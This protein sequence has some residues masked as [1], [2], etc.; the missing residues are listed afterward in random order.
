M[1][2]RRTMPIFL[3]L[4]ALGCGDGGRS[5][6]AP[7]PVRNFALDSDSLPPIVPG[8]IFAP[9]SLDLKGAL[10]ALEET[11]PKRFG[12][13]EDRQ[14]IGGKGRKSFAFEVRREPFGVQFSG[15][16]VMLS[17]IIHYRGRGWYDPPIGPD[18]NGEC[19]TSD[20]PPRAR[21]AIRVTPRLTRDWQLKVTARRVKVIPMSQTE[22]D[23]CEVTFL[24]INVTGRVLEA[25]EDALRSVLPALSRQL[26]RI[27]VRTPLEKIWVDL[28]QPIRIT[29]SL[30]LLLNPTEIH[31]G[32]V[33]RERQ[34]VGADVAVRAAPRILSGERPIVASIPLPRLDSITAGEGFSMLVE[35][36]FDYSVMSGVLTAK[37]AGKRVSAAGRSL[38]VKKVTVFGIG[39]GRL[40][41]GLDFG[42]SATGRIW[43]EGTPSYEPATGLIIVP[44]LD[45]DATSAGMLVQGVA[46]LKGDA[47]REFLRAQAKVPA[48]E[49]MERVQALAV[50]E[51]NRELARGVRLAATIESS[52]PAGIQVRPNGLVVRARARGTASLDLGAELFT[53]RDSLR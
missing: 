17:A 18:I 19:G 20:K 4:P 8:T 38:E 44:D 1:N 41:L 6:V 43:F 21:L 34:N 15:D 30:W 32:A 11:V 46:W 13:L 40:A 7:E 23:Q 48:G 29:D 35:G 9:I 45:F 27:D 42:G 47:I 24:K 31:L 36:A 39:G 26:S 14:K 53:P 52:E 2:L 16:T 50:K 51:M 25:A 3:L 33:H 22:R 37:L 12:S 5:V 49:L 10:A 28:Q